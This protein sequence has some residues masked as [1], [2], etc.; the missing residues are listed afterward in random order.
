MVC[1]FVLSCSSTKT[2]LS[3]NLERHVNFKPT[4]SNQYYRLKKEVKRREFARLKPIADSWVDHR[5]KGGGASNP[6]KDP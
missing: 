4:K 6:A 3:I 5:E 2:K 1:P